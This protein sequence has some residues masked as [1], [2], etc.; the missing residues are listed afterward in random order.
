MTHSVI[1]FYFIFS[2]FQSSCF[3]LEQSHMSLYIPWDILEISLKF[4]SFRNR[5]LKWYRREDLIQSHQLVL[6]ISCCAICECHIPGEE[7]ALLHVIWK[8]SCYSQHMSISLF[9]Q[10]IVFWIGLKIL[11]SSL[12]P[13]CYYI[14]PYFTSFHLLW[15]IIIKLLLLHILCSS[16]VVIIYFNFSWCIHKLCLRIW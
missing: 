7:C 2:L 4:F 11:N 12:M 5:I 14:F 3:I 8:Y 10:L 1:Y 16:S 13:S 6:S 15:V 9:L